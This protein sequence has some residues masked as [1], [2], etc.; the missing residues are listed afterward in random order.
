MPALPKVHTIVASACPCT[1][2]ERILWP[3]DQDDGAPVVLVADPHR[4]AG[5]D[6]AGVFRDASVLAL[7]T[8]RRDEH[9]LYALHLAGF[10]Q[11]GKEYRRPVVYVWAEPCGAHRGRRAQAAIV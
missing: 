8:L 2:A 4:V 1:H 10:I 11:R 9:R 6:A 3:L 7:V 5:D